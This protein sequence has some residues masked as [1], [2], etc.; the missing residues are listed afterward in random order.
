MCVCAGC[1]ARRRWLNP[2]ATGQRSPSRAGG[3]LGSRGGCS[4]L[5]RAGSGSEAR[6][7]A[8]TAW[9]S[10]L[11]FA[12]V[13]VAPPRAP[14]TAGHGGCGG[15]SKIWDPPSWT[16]V[17]GG[18]RTAQLGVVPCSATPRRATLPG[19]ACTDRFRP[20]SAHL[21][22]L[23]WLQG[24]WL[25][26]TT[27]GSRPGPP[28]LPRRAGRGGH[29]TATLPAAVRARRW[30]LG[31]TAAWGLRLVGGRSWRAAPLEALDVPP[32][33]LSGRSRSCPNRSPGS[34]RGL[35]QLPGPGWPCGARGPPLPLRCLRWAV[36]AT[37]SVTLVLWRRTPRGGM[38]W[39]GSASLPLRCCGRAGAGAGP[40]A[41]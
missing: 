22:T 34:R 10:V 14:V 9:L 30:L 15:T 32:A 40:G 4:G 21:Q 11:R 13:D 25:T 23:L 20:S 26:G 35:P 2:A 29:G 38:P 8:S 37:G 5:G 7:A 18:S 31:S 27:R 16:G 6:A 41:S 17:P 28:G 3:R 33:G 12:G 19:P 36:P 39:G 24:L 1:A